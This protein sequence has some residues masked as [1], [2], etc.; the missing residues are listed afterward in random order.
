[1]TDPGTIFSFS[2]DLKGAKAEDVFDEIVEWLKE[3]GATVERMRRP[4]EIEALHGSLTATAIWKKNAEKTMKID[5]SGS[6]ENVHIDLAMAP[7]STEFGYDVYGYQN[8]IRS[9][10]GQVA[11]ELW[12]KLDTRPRAQPTGPEADDR[13]GT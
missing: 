3:E 7:G 8:K 13:G 11:E 2:H 1:M 6:E 5:I 10:W 4:N 9:G 12:H